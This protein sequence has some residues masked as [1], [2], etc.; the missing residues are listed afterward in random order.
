MTREERKGSERE[1]LV[2][3]QQAH[4]QESTPLTNPPQKDQNT[5]GVI[6][7]LTSKRAREKGRTTEKSQKT[8]SCEM[9]FSNFS[10]RS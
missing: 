1:K 2:H 9:V 8:E 6:S 5:K 7:I 3:P 4:R 10:H